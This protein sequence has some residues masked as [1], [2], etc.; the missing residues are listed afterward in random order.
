M[1]SVPKPFTLSITT[2]DYFNFKG[3]EYG[4]ESVGAGVDDGKGNISYAI[5][6]DTTVPD[7][8]VITV[9]AKDTILEYSETDADGTTHQHWVQSA[10]A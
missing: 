4:I 2:N 8:Q 1:P 6:L 5:I 10:A 3:V 9:S 7:D